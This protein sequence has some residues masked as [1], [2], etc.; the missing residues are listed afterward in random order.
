MKKLSIKYDM[1][2]LKFGGKSVATLEKMQ[3]IAK[4]IK[5]IYKNDK[6]I[7]IV[8]SA[9]GSKTDELVRI[10]SEFGGSSNDRELAKLL[11]LGEMESSAL[12]A[13]V[14]NSCGMPAK[15]FSAH[16]L[17]IRT[18]GDYLNA[19]IAYINKSKLEAE[20][21]KDV[22][23]VVAGFQGVNTEGEITTLGRGG[24]DTTASAIGAVFGEI[25]EIYSDFCGVFAGDPRELDFKKLTNV[26][27]RTM[28]NMAKCGSKVIDARATEIAKEFE[29]QILSKSSSE[30]E[31][32]GTIISSVESDTISISTINHLSKISI[33]FSN[34]EKQKYILKNVIFALKNI[35]FYNFEINKNI[36]SFFVS[37]SNK[38]KVVDILAKKLNLLKHDK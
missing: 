33:I 2:I 36:I 9:M 35:N 28:I 17:E 18:Y 14:L 21:E 24:S 7:I 34:E 12:M 27:Y 3:N 10:A 20:L 16:E 23:C 6:K 19:R 5:K 15:S 8:V 25:V 1:R 29:I 31:K 22:V 38:T 32:Q 30:P 11:A 13:M 26:N 37:V 4:F